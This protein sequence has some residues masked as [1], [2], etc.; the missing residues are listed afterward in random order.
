[1][2]SV[3]NQSLEW[4]K[5]LQTASLALENQSNWNQDTTQNLNNSDL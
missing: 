1:M 5:S 3:P 2:D 4:Y